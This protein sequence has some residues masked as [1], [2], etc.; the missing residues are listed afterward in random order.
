MSAKGLVL[1]IPKGRIMAKACQ[2]LETAGI[3]VNANQL[4][5]RKLTVDTNL[6]TLKVS[7]IR[8][9]DILLAVRSAAADLAIVGSDQLAEDGK[10]DLCDL[11]DLGIAQCWLKVAAPMHYQRRT[12]VVRVAT[13]FERLTRSYYAALGIQA[14]V[15]PLNGAMELAV[16]MGL[17]DEIVDLVETGKTL[18][19]NGLI[20]TDTVMHVSSHLIA[21]RDTL[22]TQHRVVGELVARLGQAVP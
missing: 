10:H 21:N 15:V 13:K 2:Y 4:A 11:Y 20:A 8:N 1:A 19:E 22:I 6:A 14:Q 16:T 12:G 7:V 5:E 17:A 18:A 9:S 3:T